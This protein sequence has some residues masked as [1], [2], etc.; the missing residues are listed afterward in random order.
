[1]LVRTALESATY[2]VWVLGDS[3][4]F[5]RLNADYARY[6]RLLNDG[7][8]SG[9]LTPLLD[10]WPASERLVSFERVVG[11]VADWLAGRSDPGGGRYRELYSGLYRSLS[12]FDVHGLG[13]VERYVIADGTAVV[14]PPRPGG[15]APGVAVALGA[16]VLGLVAEPVCAS[17]RLDTVELVELTEQLYTELASSGAATLHPDVVEG[18]AR[19]GIDVSDLGPTGPDRLGA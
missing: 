15:M 5:D 4:R 9:R 7:A 3:D 11:D 10:G 13:P 6:V 8:M 12:T 16:L 14:I 18:L 17:Y 19:Y 2:A 1:M